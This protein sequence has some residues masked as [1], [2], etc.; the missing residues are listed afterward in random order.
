MKIHE[1]TAK[2]LFEAEGIAVPKRYV[3]NTTSEAEEAALKIAGAVVVKAQILVA[4]RGK[5]G[6]ILKAN[7][8]EETSKAA[9]QLLGAIFRGATVSSVLVE[10]QLSISK[11]F[12]LGFA[13]ERAS[14]KAIMIASE[15]GG[16]D[17]EETARSRPTAILRILLDPLL[18]LRTYQARLAG[19][20]LNIPTPALA[21]FIGICQRMYKIFVEND[22]ELLESNPL[23]LTKSSQLVAL[24]ARMVIDDNA[25]YKHPEHGEGTEELTPRESSAKQMGL[26]FVELDGD[27]GIIGNGAGL[28][29]A[30]LDLVAHHGAKAANFLDVGGGAQAEQVKAA[31]QLIVKLPNVKVIL[32]NIMGGITRCDEVAMGVVQAFTETGSKLPIVSRL[33]GTREE[34]GQRI[35]SE[36]GI[37]MT[38][39]MELAAKKAVSLLK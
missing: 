39:S 31:V 37:E 25:S 12:Y 15:E 35:L 19:K 14:K 17:L 18:G 36:A 5:A 32:L 20:A 21:S 24:D 7:G 2:D 29:M 9:R 33:V 10:E 13:I 16:V 3:A 34:E 1:H 4:G 23:A 6:A 30:T 11:E 27:V 28:V 22:C 8:K 38:K 26:S